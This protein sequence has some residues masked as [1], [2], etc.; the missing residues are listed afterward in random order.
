M[1]AL[2][3]LSFAHPSLPYTEL[4]HQYCRY[5]PI[6]KEN[7]TE[8]KNEALRKIHSPDSRESLRQLLRV[9]AGCPR[10]CVYTH[11]VRAYVY[12]CV[13]VSL[14]ERAVRSRE[15]LKSPSVI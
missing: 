4:N 10:N 6:G 14:L 1:H 2:V 5:A 7:V 3:T 8:E 9:C 11:K 15:N 13:C 12:V